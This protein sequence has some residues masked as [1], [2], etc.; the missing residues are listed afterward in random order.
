MIIVWTFLI[1]G[2]PIVSY[3]QDI[4][5]K[6]E[7]IHSPNFGEVHGDVTINNIDPEQ[8]RTITHLNEL[9][10]SKSHDIKEKDIT[11]NKI[12]KILSICI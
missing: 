6:T 5:Q 12:K 2:Y 9:V 3:A 8:A 7:G 10:E 4:R 1:L 11:I